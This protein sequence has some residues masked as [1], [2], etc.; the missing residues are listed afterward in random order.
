MEKGTVKSTPRKRFLIRSSVLLESCQ[1]DVFE[2][3]GTLRS[4]EM[5][6]ESFLREEV[7]E[8]VH[9]R[10]GL[11]VVKVFSPHPQTSSLFR[12]YGLISQIYTC[13]FS[14][15]KAEGTRTPKPVLPVASTTETE[16]LKTQRM[17]CQEEV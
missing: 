16:G 6:A 3:G 17:G 15:M 8:V 1:R 7:F 14:V 12:I 13:S 4:N 10:A 11:N 9:G 2:A 5:R